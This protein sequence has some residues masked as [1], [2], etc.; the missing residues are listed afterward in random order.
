[1]KKLTVYLL[2]ICFISSASASHITGGEMFYVYN[3]FVNGEYNYT[4]TLKLLMRCNS[5]RQFS[6]PA[7]IGIFNR[8]SNV[9]LKDINVAL[10]RRE[11]L[12]L[13]SFS[14][15]ISD[16]PTV[17]YEVGYYEF[18]IS[19]P[20]SPEGYL[21]SGQFTY[22]IAGI[23][24][25]ITSNSIG[26][27]Y[28]AEIPGMGV[29]AEGSKNS[30]AVFVGSDLVV[31]CAGNFFSYS[32]AASDPDG[33]KLEY[34]FGAAYQGG[35]GG[36]AG[37]NTNS[38]PSAPPYQSVPYSFLYNAASPLGNKV[39]IDP[40]TGLISGMAPADAGIYVVTVAVSEF[41]N[42]VK[43]AVQR[44]DIQLNIA[45]CT[46]VGAK[47]QAEY[48]LCKDSKTISV[49]N[50]SVSPLIVSQEWQFFDDKG[51]DIFFSTDVT[52]NYTFPDTGTYKIKLV[53]NRGKECLILPFRW[54]VCFPGFK[55]DFNW[56]G[57]C[58][59]KPTQFT[60]ASTTTYGIVNS[61]RWALG[62]DDITGSTTASRNPLYT[63][64]GMGVKAVRLIA[65]NSVGCI[66]TVYK[67]ITV[68]DKPELKVVFRDS[69]VCVNDK[70]QLKASGNGNFSWIPLANMTGD[71]TSTPT[72][73]PAATTVYYVQLEDDG[74]INRDSVKV[75]VTD[76]VSLNA[77]PDTTIC[78]SDSIRLRIVSD[79][80]KY[81]WTP[82]SQTVSPTSKM[83]VVI[84]ATT[85]RYEVTASIGGCSA[86][87]QIHVTSVPY[88]KAH[89]GNDTTICYNT[90]AQ[91]HAN[92]DGSSFNWSP[93]SL[94]SN[95]AILNPFSTSTKSTAF[96][97][98]A[99]D[100]K[101]CPKA[102]SD[103]VVIT[104]LPKINAFAG[105]DTAVIVGQPLQF[106]ASGGMQYSWS[107]IDGL[108]ASTIANPV[109]VYDR[110]N[111]G[112]RYKLKVFNTAGCADSAFVIVKVFQSVP[113]VFVPSAF[114]PN[115]DN[116]NE[117]LAPVGVGL[118][119]IK[120][121]S[122]FNRWGQMVYS[123][124]KNYEGWDGLVAGK[125]QDPGTFVWTVRA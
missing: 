58:F 66:D 45:P 103:T 117:R 49:R 24:N 76:H 2:S 63:Y 87:A 40:N 28:S 20:P 56:K 107:P 43:I 60:D 108:S 116:L 91:F 82:E 105:R 53:V 12:Q 32:F 30:S 75:R 104:V 122:V 72:V 100:D 34:S 37:G 61:W 15:C 98:S 92:S 44:K 64:A 86:K 80:F 101:G 121:F 81:A 7:S 38:P 19:V 114:S 36:G 74:C 48:M 119:Q 18:G 78:A 41:R 79:G 111:A 42:G 113:D 47:L 88:P 124:T 120:E 46:I 69:L 102:G 89:A 25:L 10:S 11:T 13:S 9:R 85:T 109:G 68:F 39:T 27:T 8:G 29:I 23:N 94:V 35:S 52:A 106:N 6:D 55:P 65:G 57:L 33:D 95:A 125:L 22:R 21:V 54:C 59:K 84:T 1:M 70:I 17:C 90:P 14:K 4:V 115:R 97:L 110:G 26:A 50:L 16:P 99:Y 77:M 31:V 51:V 96:I 123:G 83:P 71:H 93:Q 5:G 118:N 67:N 73:A 3:G 62:E 112:I